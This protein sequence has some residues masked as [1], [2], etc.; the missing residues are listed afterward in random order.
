MNE[1]RLS[2]D[3]V[4]AVI[5]RVQQLIDTEKQVP[6]LVLGRCNCQNK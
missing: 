6:G 3:E 2:N 5:N 4:N 1:I